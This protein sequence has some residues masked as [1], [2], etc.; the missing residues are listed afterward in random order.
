[1]AWALRRMSTLVD[2]LIVREFTL[3]LLYAMSVENI[4]MNINQTSIK[5]KNIATN[6]TII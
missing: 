2:V 3:K 1:M 5:E 6:A 4:L